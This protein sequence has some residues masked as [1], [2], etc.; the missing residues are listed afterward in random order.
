M[1][2]VELLQRGVFI[3][4]YRYKIH[5]VNRQRK[6]QIKKSPHR[7]DFMGKPIIALIRFAHRY[8]PIR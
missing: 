8:L 1:P 7:G 3:N 6:K 4:L 2:L 5:Y